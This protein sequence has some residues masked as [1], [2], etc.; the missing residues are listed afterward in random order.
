MV[1]TSGFLSCLLASP[2]SSCHA[3]T[4]LSCPGEVTEAQPGLLGRCPPPL[5]RVMC[6]Q[7]TRIRLFQCVP[8]LHPSLRVLHRGCAACGVGSNH[9]S[10]TRESGQEAIGW[11]IT[12]F[13]SWAHPGRRN[14]CTAALQQELPF[15][16]LKKET[17]FLPPPLLFLL[18]PSLVLLTRAEAVGYICT[19]TTPLSTPLRL[20]TPQGSA[21]LR[22]PDTEMCRDGARAE[23]QKQMLRVGGGE[24][25]PALQ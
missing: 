4:V 7:A 11:A 8:E 14:S 22:T 24:M 15:K 23:T 5:G 25:Q 9:N 1:T 12:S 19:S 20:S 16:M 2:R 18:S 21:V 3:G 13:P 6:T 17:P 10:K